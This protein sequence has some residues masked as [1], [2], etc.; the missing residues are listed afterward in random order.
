MENSCSIAL[1][2]L[3]MACKE[4]LTNELCFKW[5]MSSSSLCSLCGGNVET[6]RHALRDCPH[7][8]CVWGRLLVGGILIAGV[9]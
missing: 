8:L 2:T 1:A 4:G 5:G 3:L 9:L 6:I 7:V